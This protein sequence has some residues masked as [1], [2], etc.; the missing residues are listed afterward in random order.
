MYTQYQS[1]F[2]RLGR[3]TFRYRS[4]AEALLDI[5]S[6]PIAMCYFGAIFDRRRMDERVRDNLEHEKQCGFSLF[7]VILKNNGE[8]IGIVGLSFFPAKHGNSGKCSSIEAKI[9]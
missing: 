5:F 6:D 1:P 3:S 4:D 7:S 9:Q 2:N 8:V